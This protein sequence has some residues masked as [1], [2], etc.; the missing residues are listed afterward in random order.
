[1]WLSRGISLRKRRS[2][3]LYTHIVINAL[4][5]RASGGNH[6]IV[7]PVIYQEDSSRSQALLEVTNGCLL[8]ALVSKTVV[9]VGE[10]VSQADDGVEALADDRLD[11]IVQRQPVGLLDDCNGKEEQVILI[12]FL[13]VGLPLRFP[14]T[15][16]RRCDC[17]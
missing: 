9:H 8:L 15:G 7:V 16:I 14:H 1:M 6:M 3:K 2:W 4:R 13:F 10:G 17:G 12:C 5:G 11:I